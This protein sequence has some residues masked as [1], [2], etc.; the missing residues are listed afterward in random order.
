MY[1]KQ[2]WSTDLKLGICW[3]VPRTHNENGVPYKVYQVQDLDAGF[4]LFVRLGDDKK[5]IS[6]VYGINGSI[7]PP[8]ITLPTL[9]DLSEEEF[10]QL[11]LVHDLDL[12]TIRTI[13]DL[14]IE[15]RP[16]TRLPLGKMKT[17]DIE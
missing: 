1:L 10:F 2:H 5:A 8:K 17:W 16:T 4:L 3:A 13:Q 15:K 7:H 14:F 6:W 9:S 11:S 12:Y